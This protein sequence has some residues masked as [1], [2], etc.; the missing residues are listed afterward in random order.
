MEVR[1]GAM[2]TMSENIILKHLAEHSSS[3]R[4]GLGACRRGKPVEKEK[5]GASRHKLYTLEMQIQ[6]PTLQQKS[7]MNPQSQACLLLPRRCYHLPGS[8]MCY[9]ENYLQ[10]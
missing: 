5:T 3:R 1:K 6:I 8:G 9:E 10:C 4:E 7:F 2:M